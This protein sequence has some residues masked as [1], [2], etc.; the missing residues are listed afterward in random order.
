MTPLFWIFVVLILIIIWFLMAPVFKPIGKLLYQIWKR[1]A[2][3]I[4]KENKT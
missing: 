3:E 4:E 2:E 1:V